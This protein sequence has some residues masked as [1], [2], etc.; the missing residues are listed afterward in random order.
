MNIVNIGEQIEGWVL[1]GMPQ[2]PLDAHQ[3]EQITEFAHGFEECSY[4][5][6]GLHALGDEDLIRAAY[7]AMADYARGQM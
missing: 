5:R 7:H 6:E 4:S 1:Y 2:Q 3:R